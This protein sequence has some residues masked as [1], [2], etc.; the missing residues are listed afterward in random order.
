MTAAV[1]TLGCKV[2]QYD[3]ETLLR[4]LSARGFTIKNFNEP[5][6]VYIV[7][8]CTVTQVSDGKSRQMLRRAKRLNPRAMIAVC[9]CLAKLEPSSLHAIGTDCVFEVRNADV[10]FD[11]LDAYTTSRVNQL[12]TNHPADPPVNAPR[13]TRAYVKIQEGCDR[14]CAYCIVPYA[15][16][17]AVSRPAD[18]ILHETRALLA[19]GVQEI[20][21]T[22]I[23]AASYGNDVG[24]ITLPL[25]LEEVGSLDGLARLRLSSIE[26]CAADA[27]FLRVIRNIPALC[28]HFHLSL[29]SG[30]DRTLHRMNRRYTAAEYAEAAAAIRE[31]LPDAAL[32]TDIIVGFPG[33]SG[34]DFEES[35]R[36]A[37][38]MRFMRM[39]VFEYSPRAGTPAAGFDGQIPPAVKSERSRRMRAL[40][41]D[42]A[43]DFLQAHAG[44][45]MPVLFETER[46]G[47]W[48]GHTTNYMTVRV[49]S[50][51]SLSG[52]I[53]DV[54]INGTD[55]GVL[56]GEPAAEAG[57]Y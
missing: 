4:Q 29:Q 15:R 46:G 17:P 50:T 11:A 9:G 43:R 21:L 22:G 18:E 8:T 57:N 53:A 35:L 49:Q 54:Q 42:M 30:C 36:F 16:G 44:R 38:S 40:A 25:L 14:F 7:N 12:P 37:A 41:A 55:G 10:F 5:A 48:E 26:P 27:A 45:R 23:H 20:V 56:Y 1:C 32:T 2:N 33:E 31:A 3:T 13:R 47:L 52:V 51:M 6:D 34:D 28:D 39:H 19:H 24:N